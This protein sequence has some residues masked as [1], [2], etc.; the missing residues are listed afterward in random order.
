MKN[1]VKRFMAI[2][3]CTGIHIT[4]LQQIAT[5]EKNK[6]EMSKKKIS[7][8]NENLVAWARTINKN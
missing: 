3:K 4:R 2:Q 7:K 1:I 6:R 8:K 5:M